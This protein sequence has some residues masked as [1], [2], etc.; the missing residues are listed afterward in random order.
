MFINICKWDQVSKPKDGDTKISVVASNMRDLPDHS[1]KHSAIDI[2]FHNDIIHE[3]GKN[4]AQCQKLLA[5]LALD[6]IEKQCDMKLSKAYKVLS[7]KYKGDIE[8]LKRFLFC[9]PFMNR[10]SKKPVDQDPSQDE[11]GLVLDQLSKIVQNGKQSKLNGIPQD[12]K[13]LASESL[14]GKQDEQNSEKPLI[15]EVSTSKHTMPLADNVPESSI[16][17]I[18]S[19]SRKS[20]KHIKIK[21][22]LPQIQS[23]A[24]CELEVSKVKLIIYCSCIL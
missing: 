18:E 5:S 13:G 11:G 20:S 2:C 17:I 7:I 24:E 4:H 8:E 6:Y 16:E 9:R 22:K 21:V 1:S 23:G 10:P 3:R 14:L 19:T 15:E 12:F